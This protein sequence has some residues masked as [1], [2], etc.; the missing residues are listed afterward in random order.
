M[1]LFL[2]AIFNFCSFAQEKLF[3]EAISK[4]REETEVYCWSEPEF[5]MGV[6]VADDVKA[7][8]KANDICIL[9]HNY[10]YKKKGKSSIRYYTKCWFLP[11]DEIDDYVYSKVKHASVIPDMPPFSKLKSMAGGWFPNWYL[12]HVVLKVREL[13]FF[14]F[15]EMLWSGDVVDGLIDGKG[16]GFFMSDDKT[17][18]ILSGTFKKG[19]PVGQYSSCS[20]AFGSYGAS[21]GVEAR[22]ATLSEFRNGEAIYAY[23]GYTALI[24][25][26]GSGVLDPKYIAFRD[27]IKRAEEMARE[28]KRKG[29]GPSIQL[30]KES[31]HLF[32]LHL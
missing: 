32:Y 26:D 29:I 6:N 13:N 21:G 15:H 23:D 14:T 1:P 17:V 28:K 19:F 7:Y 25:P 10:Q 31:Y 4:G 5:K 12:S 24:S 8:A 16:V 27:S 22:S 30:G 3:T 11:N 18:H 9:N 2:F 20:Y